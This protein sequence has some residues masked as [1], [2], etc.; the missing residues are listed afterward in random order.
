MANL[1]LTTT[2][3][4]GVKTNNSGV[5]TYMGFSG[6][7]LINA[8]TVF[9]TTGFLLFGYD[10]GV[11]S[12]LITG[13]QFIQTFPACDEAVQGKSRAALLQATYTAI[14]ELG[15]LAGAVFAL[16]AGEKLGR[17]R[18][19]QLGA[20]IMCI[21]VAIQVSAVAGYQAGL[22]FCIGRVI[23]GVGNGMNTST[24]PSW[25]AE[26]SRSHN[27][28]LLVCIEASMVATGTAI[29]YWV[30][31]GLSFVK[32][33]LNW[34]LPIALQVVFAIG[35]LSGVAFLPESPRWLMNQGRAAEAQQVVAALTGDTFDSE[36]TLL[37]TQ[38]IIQSIEQSRELGIAR[39]RD[40]FTNGPTQHFRRMLIGCSSQF[41]QQIG[42]CNA[43]I[44]FAP[45]VFQQNLGLDRQLSLI[46]GG[47]NVTVYALAAFGSYALIEKVG[48]RKMYL[49]GSAGQCLS[50]VIVFAF[51]IGEDKNRL[52]GSVFGLF[53][54]L[55]FFGAT[56][57]ELPWLTPAEI[58]PLR[59]R[60]N[61]NAASTITNWLWNFTVV[62]FVPPML[63][64]WK[65]GTFLFFAVI[66]A[67]FIPIIYLYYP[68]TAGRTLEEIDL[69]FAKA[70]NENKSYVAVAASMPKLT[71][72]QIAEESKR[73]HLQ[74]VGSQDLG[75][76]AAEST[77]NNSREGTFVEPEHD[78]AQQKKEQA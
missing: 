59:T 10:Q 58:N 68:E 7:K 6:T 47:V 19:M 78:A 63:T 51:Y 3:P 30:D 20:V 36:A 70:Y 33:S 18:M 2:L 52:K 53:L 15:C 71:D 74:Q 61:A 38:L 32:T 45:L 64:S 75:E 26:T 35:L 49:V 5:P 48:R 56:W 60:T 23:T 22:Q 8:I 34:R 9:A 50:M 4:E 37:Q 1:E 39:K 14:Y 65:W 11:M 24:I 77:G 29:A 40:L 54:Y 73:L 31:F 17:R 42:G 44:Y 72:T 62:E 27:R 67:C 13:E 41:F 66:N 43:V 69:I 16:F 25:V 55:M 46:L 28:G 12:G 21:G 76:E 57:L